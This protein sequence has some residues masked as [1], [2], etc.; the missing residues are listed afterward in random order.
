MHVKNTDLYTRTIY[1]FE[2]LF[3]HGVL[4]YYLSITFIFSFSLENTVLFGF[5]FSLEKH[6]NLVSVL[7]LKNSFSFS[8]FSKMQFSLFSKIQNCGFSF[9]S[10]GNSWSPCQ[11]PDLPNLVTQI[12]NLKRL[13]YVSQTA[14][15]P[16]VSHDDKDWVQTQEDKIGIKLM[17]NEEQ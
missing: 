4:E 9:T 5:S 8:L 10:M 3:Y 11:T 2:I 15:R 17:K 16:N 7:V 6:F 14:D 13:K 1:S 12:F